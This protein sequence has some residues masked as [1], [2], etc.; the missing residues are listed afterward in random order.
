M[1]K[2]RQGEKRQNIKGNETRGWC[3]EGRTRREKERETVEG[4]MREGKRERL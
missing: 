1:R 3:N 2:E 4:K